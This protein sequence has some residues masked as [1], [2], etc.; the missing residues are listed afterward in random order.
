MVEKPASSYK[1]FLEQE[2]RAVNERV[3]EL[4]KEN[5]RLRELWDVID[6]VRETVLL[7]DDKADP[8]EVVEAKA[9]I[10]SLC[11]QAQRNMALSGGEASEKEALSTPVPGCPECGRLRE[12]VRRI[13]EGISWLGYPGKLDEDI[14]DDKCAAH[15]QGY[16]DALA[17]VQQAL[18]GGE[19]TINIARWEAEQ[20]VVEAAKAERT[21]SNSAVA[22]TN[23]PLNRIKKL[24]LKL[25]TR[26]ACILMRFVKV[27]CGT[28]SSVR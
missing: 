9:R 17:D 19:A 26:I 24:L 8:R 6:L 20:A 1:Q 10:D 13:R 27:A 18:S 25:R 22:K 15:E 7:L 2:I 5:E 21:R 14:P 11:R 4:L 28:G 3:E 16:N 23:T 12:Q